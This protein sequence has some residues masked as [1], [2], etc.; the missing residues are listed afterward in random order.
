M[1]RGIK[2]YEESS[3]FDDWR[4]LEFSDVEYKRF[5]TRGNYEIHTIICLYNKIETFRKN[6]ILWIANALYM[7]NVPQV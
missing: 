4:H 1:E 2:K 6:G 3:R 5:K 7:H